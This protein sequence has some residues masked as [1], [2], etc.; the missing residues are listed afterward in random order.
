LFSRRAE[1][2]LP[3]SVIDFVKV[4]PGPEQPAPPPAS[5]A[6]SNAAIDAAAIVW[7]AAPPSTF[8]PEF[9]EV[10]SSLSSS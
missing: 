9:I 4:L 7:G 3:P 1:T 6:T 8:F 10:F 2:F 5:A